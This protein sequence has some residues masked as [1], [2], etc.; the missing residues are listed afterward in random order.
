MPKY[1]LSEIVSLCTGANCEDPPSDG[2]ETLEL[3]EA[4]AKAVLRKRRHRF[5]KSKPQPDHE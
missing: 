4:E 5:R 1:S 3:T 2:Y